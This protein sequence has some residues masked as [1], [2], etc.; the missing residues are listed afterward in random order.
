MPPLQMMQPETKAVIT[1]NKKTI[2]HHKKSKAHF[3]KYHAIEKQTD[4]H[5]QN[6]DHALDELLKQ[7][8]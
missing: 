1:S 5:L 3:K 4:D 7:Q 2:V 6:A 8:P